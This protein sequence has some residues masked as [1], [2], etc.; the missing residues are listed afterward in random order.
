MPLFIIMIIFYK[1]ICKVDVIYIYFLR[2]MIRKTCLQNTLNI[3]IV[4]NY[5]PLH[6]KSLSVSR[7][8]IFGQYTDSI[9]VVTNYPGTKF[10]LD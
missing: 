10:I 4:I 2:A 8:L 7:Q 5:W 9:I 1:K 6:P 3:T